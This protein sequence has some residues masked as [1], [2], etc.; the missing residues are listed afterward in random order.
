MN[1][2]QNKEAIMSIVPHSGKMS[3]LDRVVEF[4][5]QTLCITTEVDITPDSMFFDSEI[6]GIPTWI[7]FEYMAQSISALSG[8]YG[9]TQNESP[10][11][12]FIMS[13]NSFV[14]EIPFFPAGTTAR[15][16][17]KQTMRMDKVVTF[18]GKIFLGDALAATAT[19]NTIE[20][21]DPKAMLGI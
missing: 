1:E 12:G 8:I 17:V 10:K 21:D 13:V 2:Y 18:D 7:G 6:N 14:S 11:V 16:V 3:L 9:R 15:M 5:F 4:D 19:L 20:V